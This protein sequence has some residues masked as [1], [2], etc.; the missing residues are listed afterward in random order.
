MQFQKWSTE[1]DFARQLY[2]KFI[3][4]KIFHIKLQK[5]AYSMN[6]VMNLYLDYRVLT[7]NYI[8]KCQITNRFTQM[9]QQL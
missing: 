1:W 7:D 8:Y 2:S 5:Q 3:A 9:V 4:G 6:A